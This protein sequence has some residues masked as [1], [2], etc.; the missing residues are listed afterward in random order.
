[1]KKIFVTALMLTFM[2]MAGVAS[3]QTQDMAKVKCAEFN[4]GDQ[5]VKT[6]IVFWLDGYMSAQSDNT[7][8]SDEW[9]KKLS[10]HMG[11]YCAKNPNKTIM[12]AVEE[13]PE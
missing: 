6:Y 1:M 3:A 9:V 7:E 8:M 10:M 13:M 5:N 12:E 4:Q 11:G 2:A